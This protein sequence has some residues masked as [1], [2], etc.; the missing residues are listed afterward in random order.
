VTPTVRFN[1]DASDVATLIDFIGQDRPGLLY[2]LAS[3]I[4]GAAC[5]IELVMIDTEAHK[6]IDV[7]YVTR[8]GS[9]LSTAWQQRL[10][11]ELLRAADPEAI[12]AP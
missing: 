1:N 7:F 6:A 2:D 10:E 12:Q 9:K 8:N 11:K 5:N 4:S 3:G